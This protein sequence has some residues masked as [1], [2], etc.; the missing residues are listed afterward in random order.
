MADE[1]LF[2]TVDNAAAMAA[3]EPGRVKPV[4]V[5]KATGTNV[6]VFAFDAGTGLREH[7]AQQPVLLQVLEGT[8]TVTFGDEVVKLR[9]GDLLHIEEGIVHSV[10]AADRAKLQLMVLMIDSPGPSKI[11]MENYEHLGLK[12]KREQ[13]D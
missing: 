1:P 4:S 9:P 13:E 11:P 2:T 10:E 5:L 7:V 8:L 12:A 6:V 3:Y